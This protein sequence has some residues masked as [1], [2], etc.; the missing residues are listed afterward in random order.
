MG[1]T[2]ASM[3]DDF[4]ADGIFLFCKDESHKCGLVGEAVSGSMGN[5]PFQSLTSVRVN[6]CGLRPESMN[7]PG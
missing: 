2:R 3:A 1:V 4:S 6:G 5:I 7:S